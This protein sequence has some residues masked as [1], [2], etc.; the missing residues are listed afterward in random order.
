MVILWP[1]GDIFYEV[2]KERIVIPL[3]KNHSA[4]PYLC[5]ASD[6]SEEKCG[7]LTNRKFGTSV[8]TTRLLFFLP[9][10]LPALNADSQRQV[11]ASQFG[12][13]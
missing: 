12:A 2:Y 3:N 8:L 7:L 5:S 11:S 10:L 13:A 6:S 4:Q 1:I 9:P